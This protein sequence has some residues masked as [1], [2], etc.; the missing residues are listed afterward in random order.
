MDDIKLYDENEKSIIILFDILQNLFNKIVY[1]I[2][3]K[4]TYFNF[5]MRGYNYIK[6]T[7]KIKYLGIYEN[8]RGKM[9][10]ENIDSIEKEI[11]NIISIYLNKTEW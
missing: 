2:N 4:K 10:Q 8:C 11:L 6:M 1:R 5:E 9:N 7:N 3:N